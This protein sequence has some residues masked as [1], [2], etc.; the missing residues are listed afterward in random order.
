MPHHRSCSFTSSTE[1]RVNLH[2]TLED[3][4]YELYL[5]GQSLFYLFVCTSSSPRSFGD[6]IVY[7]PHDISSIPQEENKSKDVSE[8]TYISPKS[9]RP[10]SDVRLVPN[11]I[12][13][14]ILFVDII[15]F[16]LEVE[17]KETGTDDLS[18]W[19][20]MDPHTYLLR[21]FTLSQ[22][23][24]DRYCF[25]LLDPS[26]S[27]RKDYV[28]RSRMREGF[29]SFGTKLSEVLYESTRRPRRLTVIINPIGGNQT[30][31][32]KYETSVR[33]IFQLAGIHITEHETKRSKHA[34]DIAKE[35]DLKSTDGIVCVGGD[36]IVNEVLNGLM[37]RGDANVARSMPLGLIAAGSQN[38]L[39][40]SAAG[41]IDPGVLRPVDIVS[42][43][44][45]T[46]DEYHFGLITCLYGFMSAVAEDSDRY[47]SM[48]PAR[49]IYCALKELMAPRFW[50]GNLSYIPESDS[51]PSVRINGKL[52]RTPSEM[53]EDHSIQS[54]LQLEAVDLPNEITPYSPL[55]R[56][57]SFSGG[58]LNMLNLNPFLTPAP[59]H[60]PPLS[61]LLKRP[62]TGSMLNLMRLTPSSGSLCEMEAATRLHKHAPYTENEWIHIDQL[63]LFNLMA[64]NVS[65]ANTQ[66][67]AAC[68][69][70]HP[71]DGLLSL[72]IWY[73]CSRGEIIKYLA[74]LQSGKHTEL[75]YIKLFKVKALRF[76]PTSDCPI[77]MDG[78]ILKCAPFECQVNLNVLVPSSIQVIKS[79]AVLMCPP[80]PEDYD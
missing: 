77:N 71:S 73:K 24:Q 3:V 69:G 26:R 75:P 52:I 59:L 55:M 10:F 11:V 47:R 23:K 2:A 72:C 25:N 39:A 80:N 13:R 9:S 33:P 35:I 38:A 27:P 21:I 78:E 64:F 79:G 62:S 17:K 28:F 63:E 44:F 7:A 4:T 14:Y 15:G 61:G 31:K 12:R 29:F 56:R 32:K 41:T 37:S 16:R 5:K 74:K 42:T 18:S 60:P 51:L 46:R 68:P 22:R 8:S 57:A 40:M 48:G 58:N 43:Y 54:S 50:K 67:P 6:R 53:K 45:P 1:D 19:D 70:A 76:E 49:Y 36:G 20:D 66:T 30:A 65:G 34:F